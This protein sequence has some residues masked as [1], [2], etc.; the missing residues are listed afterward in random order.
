MNKD[1][2]WKMGEEVA[3]KYLKKKG[4][5]IIEQNYRTKYAEIDIIAKD[6]N[7]LVFVEVRTKTSERFG[8]PEET[9]NRKKLQK[10]L[11]NAKAYVKMKEWEGQY[12]IDA[13]CIILS[14]EGKLRRINHYEEI[15]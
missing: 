3:R 7:M 14:P 2:I 12:R 5:K 8:L 4:Y 9:I 11:L 10:L 15:G 6:Q 1:E 13:V